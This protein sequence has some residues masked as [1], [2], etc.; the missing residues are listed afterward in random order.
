MTNLLCKF[1]LRCLLDRLPG[2]Y[3]AGGHLPCRAASHVA[4]LPDEE[5]GVWVRKR[6]HAHTMSTAHDTVDRGPPVGQLDEI[7]TKRQ[8]TILVNA[9]RG[10]CSPGN[11][12]QSFH[13]VPFQKQPSRARTMACITFRA[14][15]LAPGSPQQPH[16][17]S[18]AVWDQTTRQAPIRLGA[19]RIRCSIRRLEQ[20]SN[21]SCDTPP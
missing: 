16:H 12:L 2:V 8:P 17:N 19:G 9:F 20:H 18:D 14:G 10:D 7:L 4:I 6:E 1:A 3:P 15:P 11:L 5:N 21:R 13:I